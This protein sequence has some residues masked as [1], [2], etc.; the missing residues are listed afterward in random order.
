MIG[1]RKCFGGQGQTHKM[2]ATGIAKTFAVSPRDKANKATKKETKRENKN[3][4]RKARWKTRRKA[5][6]KTRRK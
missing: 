3:S 4:R 6:R 2:E 5:I 1:Y